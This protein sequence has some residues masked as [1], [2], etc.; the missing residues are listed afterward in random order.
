MCD[1]VI[2]NANHEQQMQDL[3]EDIKE[4]IDELVEEL[5]EVAEALD[6]LNSFDPSKD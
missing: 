6:E 1:G 5:P 2:Q 4:E 3:V